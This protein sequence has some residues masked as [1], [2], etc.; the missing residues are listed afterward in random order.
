MKLDALDVDSDQG[1]SDGFRCNA[2]LQDNWLVDNHPQR[3]RWNIDRP[4]RESACS[5][6]WAAKC[7][8]S[9]LGVDP[10]GLSL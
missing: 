9:L 5:S 8:K 6:K 3:Y 7:V 2:Q 1:K 10:N 4:R